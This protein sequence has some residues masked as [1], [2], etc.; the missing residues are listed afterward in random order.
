MEL[1]K[2]KESGNKYAPLRRQRRREGK[3]GNQGAGIRMRKVQCAG[4]VR[5]R[6]IDRTWHGCRC[7]PCDGLCTDRFLWSDDHAGPG[8]GWT[9]G[10]LRQ[11][12]EERG[13]KRAHPTGQELT[14]AA[15]AKNCAPSQRTG[16]AVPGAVCRRRNGPGAVKTDPKSKSR[17][18][19]R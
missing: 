2:K 15:R 1:I 4:G 10:V 17:R 11:S 6:R 13:G 7:G 14:A 3:R 16:A 9:G 19:L 8:G 12:A 5:P 18:I